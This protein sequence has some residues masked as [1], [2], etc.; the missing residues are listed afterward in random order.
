MRIV[1]LTDIF[2][3]S[4]GSEFQIAQKAIKVSCE[5]TA[6]PVEI[7]THQKANNGVA[8]D[9]W[10]IEQGLSERV[11]VNLVDMRLAN[12]R[13]DHPTRLH[14]IFDLLLLWRR[15]LCASSDFDLLWKCGQA[16]FMFN[17]P[18]LALRRRMVVGPVSGYEYPPFHWIARAGQWRLACKYILYAALIAC[19]RVL[20]RLILLIPRPYRMDLLL[21][22]GRDYRAI[23]GNAG[24]RGELIQLHQYTEVDLDDILNRTS[25]QSALCTSDLFTPV[26]PRGPFVLWAG[27]FM[28]RKN[29]QLAAEALLKFLGRCTLFRAVM[30]GDGPLFDLVAA[31]VERA[32]ERADRLHLRRALPRSEFIRLLGQ[33]NALLVTSWRE[34]NS[35]LIFE[36]LAAEVLV[37]SPCVSGMSDVVSCAGATYSL[38]DSL[39]P[40]GI[41]TALDSLLNS[42]V[43][44]GGRDYLRQLRD[45]EQA[46]VREILS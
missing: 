35:V 8:I 39:N 16:N 42:D 36:A 31:R 30:I 12:E 20:T 38:A 17:L 46:L 11:R 10:L 4:K 29:P 27:G 44:A 40:E 3:P 37:L 14:C 21:A 23:A 2:D 15:C 41:S 9:R 6:D 45:R 43:R 32:H 22:T 25:Q 19:G 24:M 26:V 34:A 7:W 5:A 13:G 28:H 33:A 1:I 18:F